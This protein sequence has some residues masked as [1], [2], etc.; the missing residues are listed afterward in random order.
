MSAS[1]PLPER[2]LTLDLLRG[3]AALAV[4]LLH[5]PGWQAKQVLPG[6]YLAVD[7]FFA[8]SG[9]VLAHAYLHRFSQ[10]M[11]LGQFLKIRATRLYP[12]YAL[13]TLLG[14]GIMLAAVLTG[15]DSGT[16]SDWVS[17]LVFNLLCLPVPESLSVSIYFPFPFVFPAWSLF[18][19]LVVNV[20]FVVLA[21][22]LTGRRLA[23]LLTLGA[24][25]LAYS[26]WTHGSLDSGVGFHSFV[27]GGM[28]V[29][30]SFFAGVGLY[31]LWRSG[32]LSR[33]HAAFGQLAVPLAV[34]LMMAAFMIDA[35][36]WRA[37]F[38][39]GVALILFPAIIVLGTGPTPDRLHWLC[40]TLGAA[41][42]PLYVLHVPLYRLIFRVGR[43]LGMPTEPY[44][45]VIFPLSVLFVFL[46]SIGPAQWFDRRVRKIMQ[47]ALTPKAKA[48]HT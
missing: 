14:A 13:A 37:L 32:S 17:S 15:R 47:R 31:R 10:G 30:F 34:G 38:D 40:T 29:V 41:S 9:F 36:P 12:L 28:R 46:V 48:A 24:A 45:V 42:Y 33:I 18:W 27:D 25:L 5:L 11:T 22:H 35:G 2:F 8:L 20:L 1:S 7:L 23:A 16:L 3:I 44:A 26:A 6:A 39:A 43:A 21:L 4:A 19:E